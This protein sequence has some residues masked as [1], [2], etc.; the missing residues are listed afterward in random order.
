MTISS[1]VRTAGPYAGTG[2]TATFPFAFKVFQ[3]SD[4]M[5]VRTNPDASI[6]TLVLS[7]DYTVTLNG[8]QDTNPGGSIALLSGALA[9][10]YSL[11][12]TSNL[13]TLQPVALTNQ[14]GFYPKV[15]EA[16]LDR[17]VILMQQLGFVNIRQT[18]RVPDVQG[19]QPLPPAGQR[20]NKVLSFDANGNPQASAPASGS[21]LDFAVTLLSSLGSS[22]IGFYYGG[23]GAVVRTLQAVLR[24]YQPTPQTFGAVGDG[25]TDDTAAVQRWLDHLHETRSDGRINRWHKITSQLIKPES[26]YV[27]NIHG[28]GYESAGLDA[29]S[30]ASGAV[31]KL[32]GGSGVLA[33][34]VWEGFTIKA[35]T[36]ATLVEAA[37]QGGVR[38]NIRWGKASIG[39]LAH[40]EQAG[41][42]TEWVTAGGEFSEECLTALEYR[43]SAGDES[44]HGTGLDDALI[45]SNN[46]WVVFVGANCLPYNAPLNAQI[47]TKKAG[48]CIVLNNGL[49]YAYF[50]GELT[51][52]N[53]VTGVRVG[54]GNACYLV[55][56]LAGLSKFVLGTLRPAR[57]LAKLG[58]ADG[59]LLIVD[60]AAFL[61]SATVTPGVNTSLTDSNVGTAVCMSRASVRVTAAGYEDRALLALNHQG[62]GGAG[63][64][65]VLCRFF[66]NLGT[67]GPCTFGVDANGFIT[68]LVPATVPSPV[69]VEVALEVIDPLRVS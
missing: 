56:E 41:Q 62:Y 13:Q 45:N 46:D 53:F 55:G 16:A 39:L 9:T 22:L 40:N 51:L 68:I 6:T 20:A 4:L 21:V 11:D 35:N 49:T 27:A 60:R 5:V 44:F 19:V 37:G 10:G 15:I 64:A 30:I 59:N 33:G 42:F 12:M 8:D 58:P 50:T 29:S 25:V 18:L 38:I 34:A 36:G 31:V 2:A 66:T 54:G 52:E 23:V 67:Y 3:A 63:V 47:W 28:S 1:Q 17:L 14:G 32:I 65:N 26:P 48:Q 7:S 24:D 57:A 43:R 69:T 61:L